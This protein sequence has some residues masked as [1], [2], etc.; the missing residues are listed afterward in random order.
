MD[1]LQ[2]KIYQTYGT[3]RIFEAR[4]KILSLKMRVL[5]FVGLGCVDTFS[6]KK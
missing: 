4:V 6:L 1:T 5:N 2:E 3:A